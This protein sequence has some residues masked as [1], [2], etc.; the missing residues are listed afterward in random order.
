[1]SHSPHVSVPTTRKYTRN[2]WPLKS[3]VLCVPTRPRAFFIF[4][5]LTL[6]S[7][8]SSVP[9][10]WTV[11]LPI[12]PLLILSCALCSHTFLVIVLCFVCPNRPHNCL[13][14]CVHSLSSFLP[15]VLYIQ[16]VLIC[17][18]TILLFISCSSF[19][20]CPTCPLLP[21]HCPLFRVLL[22]FLYSFSD[23]AFLT[24]ILLVPSLPH[25]LFLYIFCVPPWSSYLSSVLGPF[26]FCLLVFCLPFLY[27]PT[28]PLLFSH[29]TSV[30][31]LYCPS[32]C[33][34]FCFPSLSSYHL[35]F[36]VLSPSNEGLR[37]DFP[38]SKCDCNER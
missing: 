13:V 26:I 3:P 10:T 32:T 22:L 33:S 29:L 2:Y 20:H 37:S 34:L 28:C 16:T 23:S 4:C 30:L 19:L 36:C 1:M 15:C 18:L 7:Q 25:L 6:S 17:V 14:F 11:L 12:C 24:V 27:P 31:L 38:S 21:I 9:C 5:L 8:L 35:L